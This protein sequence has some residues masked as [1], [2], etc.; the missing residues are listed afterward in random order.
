MEP[1][2]VQQDLHPA[3]PTRR[4]VLAG[5]ATFALAN[6]AGCSFVMVEPESGKVIVAPVF[7]HGAG[8]GVTGCDVVT[9]PVFLSEE[10]GLQILREE[11]AK[12]RI[13]LKAGETLQGVVV[14]ARSESYESV[15]KGGKQK[16]KKS[17]VE[18]PGEAKPLKL[19]GMD[20]GKEI[21]V[22]FVSAENYAALGGTGRN[23]SVEIYDFKDAAQYV[24][25]KAKQQGKDRVFLGIFY[26]PSPEKVGTEPSKEDAK[27]L[28][29]QQARDFVAW[30]KEQKAIP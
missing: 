18:V 4:D 21:A 10:E 2:P 8:R 29:R 13:Q 9:P 20:S 15:N 25:A 30:L 19:S 24:A 28:L 1:K 14:P 26:D 12:H 3:Y 6:L 22:E 16:F 23:G 17:V 7:E 5:A 11:L 27:K